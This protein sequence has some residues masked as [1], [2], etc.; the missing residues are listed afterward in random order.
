MGFWNDRRM[1]PVVVVAEGK[2]PVAVM[3]LIETPAPDLATLHKQ[4]EGSFEILNKQ[5]LNPLELS[6]SPIR[7]MPDGMRAFFVESHSFNERA[8]DKKTTYYKVS[9]AV[10]KEM[11]VRRKDRVTGA[12]IQVKTLV[13]N[14]INN[15]KPTPPAPEVKAKKDKKSS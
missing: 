11:S 10:I 3:Q 2:E 9:F 5:G 4:V 8:V 6:V 13:G 7:E 1:K 14:G 12:E 15:Y